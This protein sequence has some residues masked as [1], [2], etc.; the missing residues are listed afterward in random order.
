[1][2][3]H[4]NE[5]MELAKKYGFIVQAYGGVVTLATHESQKSQLGMERYEE[6]QKMNGWRYKD[7]E[8]QKMPRAW[9]RSWPC[10]QR[11]V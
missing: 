8:M 7:E 2:D 9:L 3:N 4:W 11:D 1:M 5:V 6:I 10:L